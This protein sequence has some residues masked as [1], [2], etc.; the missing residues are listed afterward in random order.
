METV[1]NTIAENLG[2]I[3]PGNEMASKEGQF[4]L[5]QVPD[6]TGKVYIVTGGN[7]GMSVS[8]LPFS[9]ASSI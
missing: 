8:P 5:D 4:S 1:K 9:H 6:L 2:K 3:I 7:S